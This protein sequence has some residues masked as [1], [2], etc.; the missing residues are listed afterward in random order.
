MRNKWSLSECEGIIKSSSQ[1]YVRVGYALS[2]IKTFELHKES[3]CK[4]FD[5]YVRQRFGYTRRWAKHNIEMMTVVSLIF[6]LEKSE[7]FLDAEAGYFSDVYLSG[8]VAARL[9]KH[10][11]TKEGLKELYRNCADYARK[12]GVLSDKCSDE[13]GVKCLRVTTEDV[14]AVLGLSAWKRSAKSMA[15][16]YDNTVKLL[17]SIDSRLGKYEESDAVW[18]MRSCVKA[19]KDMVEAK[20]DIDLTDDDRKVLIESLGKSMS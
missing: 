15:A 10:C 3:G 6:D 18:F 16:T 19:V 12:R 1:N 5:S 13:P 17:D 8:K 14:D 2:L 7:D 9:Y 20:C 4:T 11:K